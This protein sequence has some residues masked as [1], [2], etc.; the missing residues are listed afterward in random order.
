MLHR[1]T[2]VRTD[3]SEERIASIIRVTRT[4]ELGKTL[5]AFIRSVLPLLVTTNVVPSS[6]ILVTL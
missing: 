3:I 1:V 5:A 4:S 2:V 6:P